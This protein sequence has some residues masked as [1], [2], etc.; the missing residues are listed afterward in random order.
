MIET[1]CTERRT[2]CRQRREQ[3]EI[4]VI[5]RVF[6]TQEGGLAR[7]LRNDFKPKRGFLELDG[8]R[9]IANE[10]N[11]LIEAGN[12]NHGLITPAY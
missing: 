9:Q 1:R 11:G 5:G 2:R 7:C 8:A 12:W 3:T 4:V 6:C 10:E